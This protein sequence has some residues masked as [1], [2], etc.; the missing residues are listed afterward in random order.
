M[1][2][3]LKTL[4]THSPRL[5]RDRNDKLDYEVVVEP[6]ALTQKDD[7]WV[8]EPLPEGPTSPA[9]SPACLELLKKITQ[10][11]IE[12]RF[13]DTAKEGVTLVTLKCTLSPV[14]KEGAI[15]RYSGHDSLPYPRP[16]LKCNDW[17]LLLPKQAEVKPAA[18]P[19][20][21][22]GSKQV[23]HRPVPQSKPDRNTP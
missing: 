7:S 6:L 16:M 20:S 18:Q 3:R 19:A 23:D 17:E 11:P 5:P 1:R 22:N 14:V 8:A 4:R 10:S 13:F 12:L 15:V 2:A 21:Q 9:F